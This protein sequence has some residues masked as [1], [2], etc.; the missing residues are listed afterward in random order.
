MTTGELPFEDDFEA[1][2]EN[3]AA[4]LWN[5]LESAGGWTVVSGN[6]GLVYASLAEA[7]NRNLTW[8]GDATWTNMRFQVDVRMSSGGDSTRIYFAVRAAER[9]G[10]SNKLDY[11]FGY[12]RGNG[13]VRLGK[14]LDGST[15]DENGTVDTGV[16]PTEWTSVA[17]T[18]DGDTN[19]MEVNCSVESTHTLTGRDAGFVALGVD[20]GLAEFDNVMVTAP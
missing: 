15:S 2:T 8:A 7:S 10:D 20:S 18:V 13:Q 1:Y 16:D 19:S 14:Y 17:I 4:T 9:A 3:G 12:L 11:Y 5:P 6:G